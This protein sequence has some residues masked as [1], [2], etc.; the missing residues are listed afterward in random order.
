MKQKEEVKEKN[1]R[2]LVE[3]GV[4]QEVKGLPEGWTYEIKDRDTGEDAGAGG[5]PLLKFEIRK[6]IC[7]ECGESVEFGSGNFAN[8]IPVLD[9]LEVNKEKG[10]PHP[11]GKWICDRCNRRIEK[12][13][14]NNKPEH[15]K[16][17]KMSK[18]RFNCGHNNGGILNVWPF[19]TWVCFEC[20]NKTD[21]LEKVV[22]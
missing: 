19:E 18:Y 6:D 16:E 5:L 1:I 15:L 2:I 3:G 8:R 7:V 17:D 12:E 13:Y 10:C 22:E 21:R 9:S 4:V 20:G 14:E 11:E